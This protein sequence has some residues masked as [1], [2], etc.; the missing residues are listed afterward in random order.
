MTM[1]ENAMVSGIFPYN[2]DEYDHPDYVDMLSDDEVFAFAQAH[3]IDLM[4]FSEI[5]DIPEDTN[6]DKDEAIEMIENLYSNQWTGQ[7]KWGR[8]F[9]KKCRKYIV[10]KGLDDQ[11]KEWRM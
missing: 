8:N 7:T 1:L 3:D 4:V 11:V 10:D 5:L 6:Y 9:V 2:R